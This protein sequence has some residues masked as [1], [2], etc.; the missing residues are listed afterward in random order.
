LID[1]A[2]LHRALD[3]ALDKVAMYRIKVY[4]SNGKRDVLVAEP[5]QTFEWTSEI[6]DFMDKHYPDCWYSTIRL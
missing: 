1:R 4:R 2:R 5:K 3:R 6:E